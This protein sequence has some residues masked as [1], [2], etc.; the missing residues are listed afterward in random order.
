M[1][2]EA[3]KISDHVYFIERGF[4]MSFTFVKGRRQIENFWSND[5][6]VMSPAS[7]FG[8]VPSKEFIQLMEPSEVFHLS[9]A[10]IIKIFNAFPESHFI[11]RAVMN[12]YF[13]RYRERIH[14]LHHLTASKRY[15]KL[16]QTIPWLEQK[17]PQ[18][19]IASYLGIAPQSL[20]RL[21]KSI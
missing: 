21:R 4:A 16:H 9:Y 20:S 18:D 3:P 12:Q 10:S 15:E 14:D 13:E 7:F 5:H 8:Q 19:Y 2:L 1:L 17:I 11:Y 6:I